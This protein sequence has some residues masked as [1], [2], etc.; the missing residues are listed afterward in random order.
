MASEA[1]A[2]LETLILLSRGRPGMSQG[3]R[4][5]WGSRLGLLGLIA[6]VD[7]GGLS[8]YRVGWVSIDFEFGGVS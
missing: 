4:G 7:E 1:R 5:A 6:G 3:D 8:R 2:G